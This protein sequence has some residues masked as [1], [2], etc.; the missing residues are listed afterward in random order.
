MLLKGF[1]NSRGGVNYLNKVF[2]RNIVQNCVCIDWNA[3][4]AG[5]ANLQCARR[6]DVAARS[7]EPNK[8]SA[9]NCIQVLVLDSV[10]RLHALASHIDETLLLRFDE[11]IRWR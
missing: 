2:D 9:L 4:S 5:E 11:R 10:R 6:S 8:I 3:T 7:K 1:V